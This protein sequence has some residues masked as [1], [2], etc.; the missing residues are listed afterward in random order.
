MAQPP[1]DVRQLLEATAATTWA[2]FRLSGASARP[3]H[4]G[5][6]RETVVQSFLLERLPCRFRVRDPSRRPVD[7]A[8]TDCQRDEREHYR[9][10]GEGNV[11]P[12]V[13]DAARE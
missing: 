6:P 12:E 5:V 8:G 10:G 1:V 3:D 13:P 4:K 2:K 7:V 11:G 9:H